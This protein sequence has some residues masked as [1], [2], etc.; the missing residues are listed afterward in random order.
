M[1]IPIALAVGSLKRKISSVA[2]GT[3]ADTVSY[4]YDATDA[5]TRVTHG[6][7]ITDYAH[8]PTRG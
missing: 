8:D 7:D 6:R 5:V 1:R 4:E 2:P 3:R